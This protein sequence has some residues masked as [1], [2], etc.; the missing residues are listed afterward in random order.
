M[1]E[2]IVLK[3]LVKKFGSNKA[4]NDISLTSH[5]GDIIGLI[6]TNGS[7]K[8][9]VLKVLAGALMPTAGIISIDG[10][11]LL[12]K[13]NLIKPKIGYV[14]EKFGNFETMSVLKFLSF[15]TKVRRI[16]KTER[17]N[18]INDVIK[19]CKLDNVLNM[20]IN[21]LSKGFQKRVAF[22]QAVIHNPLILLLD[23]PFLGID[24]K[25]KQ[26]IISFIKTI[27]KDK[28]LI[29]ASNDL[30]AIEAACSHI[31]IM[32][33][34]KII[35][36]DRLE[37]MLSQSC[38]HSATTVRIPIKNI[39]KAKLALQ[40]LDEITNI[41]ENIIANDVDLTIFAKKNQ[42]IAPKILIC[43]KN[44]NINVKSFFT[45]KGSLEEIFITLT[46]NHNKAES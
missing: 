4:V 20:P 30:D 23:E 38:Y 43:L 33:K 3:N 46:E 44:N 15:I 40:K 31:I 11:N 34:G 17:Q 42:M 21:K 1:Q 29:V 32:N 13:A 25:Q 26:D 36:K 27:A 14:P 45:N 6:G 5:L 22:A 16:K 41:E 19:T 8:S 24:A 18:A 2:I 37:K 28:T 10:D 12:D 35:A 39:A 7:G 9:T